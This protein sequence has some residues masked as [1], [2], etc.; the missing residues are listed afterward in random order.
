MGIP[1]YTN[2]GAIKIKNSMMKNIP[3]RFRKKPTPIK[4]IPKI[5]PQIVI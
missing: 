3:M 5:K 4:I 1:I 2:K